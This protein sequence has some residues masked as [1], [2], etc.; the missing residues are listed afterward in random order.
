MYRAFFNKDIQFKKKCDT[1]IT[2]SIYYFFPASSVIPAAGPP[3]GL[4]QFM[5]FSTIAIKCYDYM[6][7]PSN[8]EKNKHINNESK[9]YP[10]RV[11]GI[12]YRMKLRRT[13]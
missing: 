6:P 13:K 9:L 8:C 11:R 3:R 10:F 7:A 5:G 2:N 1:V 12:L 4:V